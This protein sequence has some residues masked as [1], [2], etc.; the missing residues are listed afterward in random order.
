MGSNEESITTSGDSSMIKS[1]PVICSNER[2]FLPSRPMILPL[3]SS[4]GISTSA[5]VAEVTISTVDRS[6]VVTSNSDV[7]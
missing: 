6:I 7:L 5:V 4:L 3:T 1:T 2:M